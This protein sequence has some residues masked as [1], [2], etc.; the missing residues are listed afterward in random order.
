ME[1]LHE[2]LEVVEG[3]T[4]QLARSRTGQCTTTRHDSSYALTVLV[5]VWW[6]IL[7]A[8]VPLRTAVLT[9]SEREKVAHAAAVVG[10]PASP[11]G[12][13][14]GR[15][16]PD[17]LSLEADGAC[18]EPTDRVDPCTGRVDPC[19]SRVDPCTSRVDPC[20]SWGGSMHQPGGSKHQ[21]GW[22]HA[23]AGGSTSMQCKWVQVPC[24]ASSAAPHHHRDGVGQCGVQGA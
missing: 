4:L 8:S 3:E 18:R 6:L 24:A 23:P 15:G 19:T 14:E 16:P 12:R 13:A 9:A 7:L 22:I 1:A 20:T 21:P 17:V 10:C 5:M 2:H 11:F